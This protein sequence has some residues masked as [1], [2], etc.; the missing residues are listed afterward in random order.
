AARAR[1]IDAL[2]ASLLHTLRAW[3]SGGDV[4]GLSTHYGV[5]LL[6]ADAPAHTQKTR[7]ALTAIDSAARASLAAERVAALA[8]HPA[9][10]LLADLEIAAAALAAVEGPLLLFWVLRRHRRRVEQHHQAR[11]D[12]LSAQARTDSLTRLGNRRAFEDDFG[13][14]I[15]ARGETGQGFTLLAMDLDGL[16]RINDTNGHP[17]GDAQIRKVA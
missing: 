5:D 8:D 11:V 17:A 2:S 12:H 10:G 6:L 3:D 1:Q 4:A 13:Q 14:V 9:T 15:A 16:K 7:V